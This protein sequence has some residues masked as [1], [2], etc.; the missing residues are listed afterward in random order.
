MSKSRQTY[1]GAVYSWHCDHMGHMNVMHYVGKF[2]EA[3]WN[4]FSS[5]GLQGKAMRE[6]KK[7]VVAVEQSIKYKSELLAGDVITIHSE[8]VEFG[9]KSIKFRH[10]MRNAET[11]VVA[12]VT[13]LT[14]LYF[15]KVARK[16]ISLPDQVK[17]N[18]QTALDA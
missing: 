16:A 8:V 6:D 1:Q 3:T 4:F 12:A 14:G 15:D 2:D 18:L 10:E 13:T 17:T 7:G 5:A 11:G 9:D